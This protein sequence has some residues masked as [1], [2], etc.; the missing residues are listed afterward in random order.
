MRNRMVGA[1]N[2]FMG[3]AGT[4][5]EYQKIV[6]TQNTYSWALKEVAN[7]IETYQCSVSGRRAIKEKGAQLYLDPDTADYFG[8]YELIKLSIDQYNIKDILT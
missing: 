3:W 2:I 4:E 8:R 1:T 7:N 6:E 5:V